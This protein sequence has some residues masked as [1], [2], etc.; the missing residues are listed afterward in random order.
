MPGP[1]SVK[2]DYNVAI[3]MRDGTT[4]FADVFRPDVSGGVPALLQRTPYDK[5]A[6]MNRTGTLDAIRA[7]MHGY[8]VVIQDV[9]GRYA[10]DGV[11]YTFVN[12]IDDGYDSVEWVAGQPWC[13]GKVGMYGVSYV[14]ATQ[15]LAAKSGAP[16][17]AAIVPGVTASDYH[18]GW[19]WQGGA[20]ELGF[21]LSWAIGALTSANWGNLSRRLHLTD[22]DLERVI[23]A[24]DN[25]THGYLHLPMKDMPHLKGELAPYYYDWLAHPENDDYWKA[26]SIEESHSNISVPAY[27]FGGWHDIFLGGTIRNFTRM[28]EL[29]ATNE[30]RKGQRLTIGPWVH[31]GSPPSVS[32]EYNFGTRAAGAAIDLGGEMLRYYD[33]WLRGEDNGVADEQPVRI[34]VEGENVWRYEDEWPLSRAETVSFYLHSKGNANTFN[35]D[36]ALSTEAPSGEESPDVYAYN[37]LLP[38]PTLGGGLCCDPAFMASG[39]YDQRPVEGRE[40]VLVYSTPP[41]EADVEVTGPITVTLFAS[42]SAH[43]T[44]FTGKLVDVHPD[45]YA[46]NL[47]DGIIRARY[48]NPQQ[49]ASL[50]Q[51]G[52]V[53][54]YTMDLWAN[55]NLFMKGHQIRLE[56]SSSNFPRFD[57][58]TNTGEE[59]GSD[60]EFVSA[61]QHVF[62]TDEYPSHVKLP[63]VPRD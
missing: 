60:L 41:L 58:N 7:A 55:S 18:E 29:G 49:P 45:G 22:E 51:P 9:R 23:E 50:L 47:T 16:S 25:L 37:P 57:R 44:D 34:F 35:G 13:D 56:I 12:E 33:H 62:H 59:I 32:G 36:G 6:G 31:G 54:E 53:Y 2:F 5:T 19:A 28:Q 27:N 52:Q 42:S 8:A 48:R 63:I 30:A 46:R 43:D 15:W 4:T 14:G 24:K 61:L 17:L 20:F 3:M 39:V 40:D 11:F 1:Y 10:S 21:N 26:V 38:V